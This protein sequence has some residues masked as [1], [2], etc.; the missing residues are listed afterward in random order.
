MT[1]STQQAMLYHT[2][3]VKIYHTNWYFW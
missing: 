3:R 1:L 2:F